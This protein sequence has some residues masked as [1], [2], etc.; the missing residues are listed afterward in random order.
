MN[1]L[2]QSWYHKGHWLSLL[3]LPL[4]ALYW[5]ITWAR[6]RLYRLG[7]FRRFRLPVPVVI[8]GNISVGGTGKT[9]FT[10]WLC[11]QLLASG[12]KPGIISRGYGARIN[13]PLLVSAESLAQDVGDEPLLLARRSNCP[14]VVCPDRVA[15]GRALLATHKV[16]IIICDDGLQHYRLARDLEIVLVDGRRGFGNG[17]L[18][19][20]GPLRE[21]R[22]RLKKVE[23]VIVNSGEVVEANCQMQLRSSVARSLVGDTVLSPADVTLVAGIGNPDRF[24]LTAIQ[25]GF[26]VTA[27]RFFADHHQFCAADFAGINTTV[28]MTEKDAVKCRTFARENW[29][30]LPVDADFS[31]EHAA[32]IMNKIKS[33]LE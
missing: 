20:A 23:L 2:E 28:L 29:Y 19:P 30:Y 17:L 8:V 1:L 12:V 32:E 26:N 24:R 18:L 11:Q 31:T 9:P 25:A 21:P 16:D 33:L 7:L 13:R 22:A 3:L 4:A 14:V 15:A 10:L 27:Q 5:L 6:R